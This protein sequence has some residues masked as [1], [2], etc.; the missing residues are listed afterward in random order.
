MI[1]P[2]NG[3]PQI[4]WKDLSFYDILSKILISGTIIIIFVLTPIIYYIDSDG[5][6]IDFYIAILVVVTLGPILTVIIYFFGKGLQNERSQHYGKTYSNIKTNKLIQIIKRIL[7]D[8]KIEYKE[9][10][11]TKVK[12]TFIKYNSLFNLPKKNIKIKIEKVENGT[13]VSIG[14][15]SESNKFLI[16]ELKNKIDKALI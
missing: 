8:N 1:K 10:L 12:N 16:E 14:K 11:D 3:I 6:D 9:Y 4:G 13:F 15:F 5:L 7:I 2:L